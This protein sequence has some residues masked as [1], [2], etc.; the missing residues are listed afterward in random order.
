MELQHLNFKFFVEPPYPELEPFV[1]VFHRWI[2]QQV[3]SPAMLI[4]VADYSHVKD[5]P[6]VV[7]IGHEYDYNLDQTGGRLGLRFSQK[8]SIEGSN[9]EVLKRSFQTALAGLALLE[10]ETAHPIRFS[11]N[12]FEISVNDRAIAPNN[13]E[14][15]EKFRPDVEAFLKSALGGAPTLKHHADPRV[16]FGFEVH[17]DTAVD[18]KAIAA[19]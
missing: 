19:R 18:W 9:A 10:G 16:R 1:P 6:G 14:T 8:A 17:S 4:D 2:Q 5:G 3:F 7:L 15:L 12:D 11:R 13:L